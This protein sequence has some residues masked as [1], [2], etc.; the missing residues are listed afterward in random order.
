[1]PTIRE[2]I[3]TW[4]FDVDN[5]EL[6]KVDKQLGDLIDKA[7]ST[8]KHIQ[9]VAQSFVAAGTKLTAFVTL[10]ILAA[11]A[12]LLKV[13]SD[14]EETRSKFN[15]VFKELSDGTRDWA[16]TTAKE[17]GRSRISL[18]GYLATLQDTFVPLGFARKDAAEFSKTLTTLAIDL[19]SFNNESE[20]DTIRSLQSAIV[21]NTETVRK[22]G[23]IIT[24]ATLNQELLNMGAAGGVKKA[25]EAQK[26]QARLQIIMA[27]TTD[28]QGDAKRTAGEFANQLRALKA[29]ATDVAA[30]F[31]A[32]LIPAALRV[33]TVLRRGVTW[34][35]NLSES[36]QKTILVTAGIVAAIGPLLIIFGSLGLAIVGI[37]KGYTTLKIAIVAAKGIM[38][39]FNATALLIPAL[40]AGIVIA[41]ALLAD[42]FYK[43]FTGQKSLIGEWLG[44]WESVK[45]KITTI[46]DDIKASAMEF[47]ADIKETFSSPISLVTNTIGGAGGFIGDLLGFGGQNSGGN[48]LSSG[49]SNIANNS[50]TNRTSNNAVSLQSNIKVEVPPGTSASQAEGIAAST[51]KIVQEEFGK[52]LRHTATNSAGV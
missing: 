46:W 39:A 34:F 51:K 37:A 10:P 2:L 21:G 47:W 23:V 19:A 12:G 25:T 27:S 38:V 40:I 16:A 3:T 31:G 29:E 1:M 28:A 13:A 24:Q 41:V 9:Q 44:S 18:E 32:I 50:A 5:A 14:A 42:D 33:V 35:G 48:Q 6:D 52:I 30:D 49:V 20:P 15:A 36:T 11:G 22:Y 43:F 45:E 8:G 26:A 4:G 7:D 17:V